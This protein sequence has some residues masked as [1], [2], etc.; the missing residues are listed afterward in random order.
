M[1]IKGLVSD[2]AQALVKLGT[3][4]YLGVCSMPDLFHFCQ[5]KNLKNISFAQQ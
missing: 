3:E 4:D 1:T 2:R 5:E